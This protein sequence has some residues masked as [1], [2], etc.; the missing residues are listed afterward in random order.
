MSYFSVGVT[1]SL[2]STP[3]NIYLVETLNAEPI[4]QSTIYTLQSLPWA[5]KLLFGF[6]SDAVPIYGMHRKPYLTMGTL[7]Y[8]LAF[9]LYSFSN[10]DSVVKLAMC[11][12]FGTMGLIQLDVMADT[13]C[14][15]RSKFEPENSKGNTITTTFTT[16]TSTSTTTTSNITATATATIITTITTITTTTITTTTITTTTTT[17]TTAAAATT[18]TTTTTTT[19]TI[20]T[21]TTTT[22][23]I[24]NLLLLL[25]SDAG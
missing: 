10:H 3:L 12:F 21:T 8:S 18:T 13:M 25:R 23:T 2:I 5:L 24:L 6:L 15:E 11:I 4:M 22:T 19:I 20:T 17:T 1:M 16:S 9:I 14:V 7:L